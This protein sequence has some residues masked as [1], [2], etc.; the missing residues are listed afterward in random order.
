MTMTA[1]LRDQSRQC[2][3]PRRYLTVWSEETEPL[4]VA[5][6]DRHRHLLGGRLGNAQLIGLSNVVQSTDDF[7]Q[8]LRFVKHQGDK[9]ERAGL[10]DI[11]GYWSDL[12]KALVRIEEDAPMLSAAAGL[13]LPPNVGRGRK[14]QQIGLNTVYLAMAR[15]FVQH[16]VAHSLMIASTG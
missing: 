1:K 3:V 9:A 15:D 4:A 13:E 16:F 6:A 10:F 14:R 2:L 8:V 5:L 7:S 11:Q 12:H